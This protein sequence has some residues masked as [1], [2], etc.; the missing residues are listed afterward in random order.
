VPPI[1]VLKIP[2]AR[3]PVKVG[4]SDAYYVDKPANSGLFSSEFTIHS[5]NISFS[6]HRLVTEL[7]ATVK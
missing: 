7:F 3:H 4:L 6:L 1:T 2:T 5:S